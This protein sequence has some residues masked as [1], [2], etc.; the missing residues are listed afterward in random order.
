MRT[1][2]SGE[3]ISLHDQGEDLP[4]MGGEPSKDRELLE[5]AAKA[6]GID[7][8]FHPELGYGPEG[9]YLKGQRS[10]DNSKYWNP[11]HDDGDA[12]RLAVKLHI[13]IGFIWDGENDQYD[14]VTAHRGRA[15]AAEQIGITERE[16]FD[17]P[18][19]TRRAIVRAA[20]S[21]TNPTEVS[22]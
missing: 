5:R 7:A 3:T 14:P 9:M 15:Y 19:A 18:A 8:E 10:P 13:N 12:L 11:L 6:A 2:S 4:R 1:N 16:V 21:L 17:E 22:P 20:A